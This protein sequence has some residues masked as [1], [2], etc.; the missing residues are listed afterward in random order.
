MCLK[1][2]LEADLIYSAVVVHVGEDGAAKSRLVDH[3]KLV[4]GAN[5]LHQ[6]GLDISLRS[7]VI[8]KFIS[9]SVAHAVSRA[10]K[11]MIKYELR[12]KLIFLKN[13]KISRTCSGCFASFQL[14]PD[15]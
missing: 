11:I 7:S 15:T 5:Y 4:L 3:N 10:N 8:I 1:S 12:N 13:C 9:P 14:H 2:W 6:L